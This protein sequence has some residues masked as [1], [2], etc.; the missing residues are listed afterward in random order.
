MSSPRPDPEQAGQDEQHRPYE[1]KHR[2]PESKFQG[3]RRSVAKVLLDQ[4]VTAPHPLP[5]TP[6]SDSP[7]DPV[8]QQA[9]TGEQASNGDQSASG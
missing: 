8:D 5:D 1:G 4:P 9:A 7:E 2:A 6:G 3:L